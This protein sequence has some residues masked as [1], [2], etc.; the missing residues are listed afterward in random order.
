M[1]VTT[2]GNT[3]SLDEWRGLIGFNPWHFWQ[4]S[5]ASVPI[6]S[7]CNSIVRQYNWQTAGAAGRTEIARAIQTAEERAKQV[8]GFWVSPR[9]EEVTLPFP[10]YPQT[11]VFRSGYAGGDARWT[12][13]QLP[14]AWVQK[15]G[16]EQRD[17]IGANQV[18]AYTDEDGDGLKETFT[19][20]IATTVTDANQIACYFSS[21]DRWDG[22]GISENWRVLPLRISIAGGI[23]TIRGNSWV[24]VKPEL[25]EGIGRGVIDPADATNFVTTLDIYRRYTYLDGTTNDNSQ[26]LLIWETPP[27]PQWAASYTSLFAGSY[28]PAAEAYAIARVGIRDAENGIVSVGEAVYT[29][30]T[31]SAIPFWGSG[32][33]RPPDRVKVR[34][35]AGFALDT[36]GKM[37]HRM[38][39]IIY[40]LA[41]AELMQ[42]IC[43]C[44]EANRELY[45][46]QFDLAR[47]S[48]SN[49]ESYTLISSQD[50]NNPLGTRRGQVLAYREMKA[51]RK[52]VH[53][54]SV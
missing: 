10:Q 27:Y 53:G 22:S 19:F 42:D 44:K 50:L 30:G 16:V 9:Y 29:D 23:A 54:F 21:A 13:L 43:A 40:K 31:W 36:N 39:S 20:S 45:R 49:D 33:L 26:A 32:Y 15:V 47:S 41:A 28:D 24:L 46:W 3:M 12:S 25:Y 34:Y 38:S 1:P 7:A 17:L 48:G 37:D 2:I 4:L 11:N 8:L 5:N 52:F 6:L 51:Y 18:L 35:L 14:S